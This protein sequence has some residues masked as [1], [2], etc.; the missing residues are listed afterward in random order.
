LNGIEYVLCIDED[1]EADLEQI[2]EFDETSAVNLA[3]F[4]EELGGDLNLLERLLEHGY[5]EHFSVDWVANFSVSRW[6]AQWNAGHNLWRLKELN[7]EDEGFRYRLIYA[8]FPKLK[9]FRVLG[10]FPRNE[11]NY[12]SSNP[13]TV[14][15]M[16]RYHQ[17]CDEGL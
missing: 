6:Q 10:V 14:R 11:F 17:L 5:E 12:E 13:R 3:L 16:E 15:V 2:A 1:A 8:F 7:L 4:L 9:H